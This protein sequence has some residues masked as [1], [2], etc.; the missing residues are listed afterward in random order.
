MDDCMLNY[1]RIGS[2]VELSK[3]DKNNTE[4]AHL[5]DEYTVCI[6]FKN[7]ECFDLFIDNVKS[8]IKRDLV[9]V[10]K[11]GKIRK[12]YKRDK[13]Y[14]FLFKNDSVLDDILLVHIIIRL[15]KALQTK[16]FNSTLGNDNN[17]VCD[18]NN[19]MQKIIEYII[20]DM[21]IFMGFLVFVYN[22]NIE[23][24]K[25]DL[26]SN[27]FYIINMITKVKV[28]GVKCIKIIADKSISNG[29]VYTINKVQCGLVIPK[30]I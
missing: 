19:T 2:D 11:S 16:N 26:Y 24:V 15:F 21:I 9:Y 6:F 10:S 30:S 20:D 3:L 5:L 1:I 13:I 18:T 28:G 12:N 23:Y 8:L 25:L 22:T 29:C 27:I 4:V 14:K 17:I 7:F